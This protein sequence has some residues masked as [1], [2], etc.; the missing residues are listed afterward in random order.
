MQGGAQRHNKNLWNE[1]KDLSG[2]EGRTRKVRTVFGVRVFEK[3]RKTRETQ[4]N[5]PPQRSEDSTRKCEENE[6]EENEK[7]RF[8]EAG[9]DNRG[10]IFWNP[11][12]QGGKPHTREFERKDGRLI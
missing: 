2:K 7:S 1:E 12:P 9:G 5:F 3:F 8:S 4:T 6:V 11:P 10:A